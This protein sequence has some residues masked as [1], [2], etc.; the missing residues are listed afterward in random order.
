MVV[1]IDEVYAGREYI[2]RVSIVQ[3]DAV[4]SVQLGLGGE[5]AIAGEARSV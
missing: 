4:R 2:V 1:L 3:H 5:A